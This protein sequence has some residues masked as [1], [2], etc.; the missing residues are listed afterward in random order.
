MAAESLTGLK[1]RPAI[2]VFFTSVSLSLLELQIVKKA[3]GVMI[4]KF[5]FSLVIR[6]F[7]R[8]K[9]E[10]SII[11]GCVR[12]YDFSPTKE[13]VKLSELIQKEAKGSIQHQWDIA[14]VG[15]PLP[16]TQHT[17]AMVGLPVFS[18]IFLPPIAQLPNSR[19]HFK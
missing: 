6:E 14:A 16:G 15:F 1:F 18:I 5:H 12:T 8:V 4:S 10:H 17:T 2:R 11:S 7:R 13:A 3:G 19:I 9:E